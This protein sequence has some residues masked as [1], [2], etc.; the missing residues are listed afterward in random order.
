MC[1]IDRLWTVAVQ[2]DLAVAVYDPDT[3]NS[4]GLMKRYLGRVA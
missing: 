2:G 1:I 3:L 4:A